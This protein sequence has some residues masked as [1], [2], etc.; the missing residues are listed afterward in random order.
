MMFTSGNRPS[1]ACHN[2]KPASG[3]TL[4]F[5]N[6]HMFDKLESEV[7]P[8][9][10]NPKTVPALQLVECLNDVAKKAGARGYCTC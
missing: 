10:L 4:K 1:S 5:P 6:V 8:L 3:V 2:A 9:Q 7:L